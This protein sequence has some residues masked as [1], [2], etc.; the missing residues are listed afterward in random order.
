MALNVNAIKK[1]FAGFAA[2]S[3]T[4]VYTLGTTTSG[5]QQVIIKTIWLCNT[6]SSARTVTVRLGAAASDDYCI[7]KDFPLAAKGQPE[8]VFNYEGS[9]AMDT[10]GDL[11]QVGADVA[12][13]VAVR[14]S[15]IEVSG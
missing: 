4:T 1:F 11:I 15:G 2:G 9:V 13:K 5:V 3:L 10:A 12:S 6:D 7:L 8:S 14:I